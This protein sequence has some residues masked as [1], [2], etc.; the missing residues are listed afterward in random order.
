MDQKSFAENYHINSCLFTENYDVIM[1]G[2]IFDGADRANAS[3]I[4]GL[5]SMLIDVMIVN[6]TIT[7][8]HNV[9]RTSINIKNNISGINTKINVK[10]SRLYAYAK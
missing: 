3:A 7:E 8:F 1:R 5:A 9:G 6:R 2:G 4:L 10:V